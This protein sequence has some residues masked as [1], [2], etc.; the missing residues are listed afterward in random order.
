MVAGVARGA[1]EVTLCFTQPRFARP[2]AL[3]TGVVGAV[4]GT[5]ARFW[6]PPDAA[7]VVAPRLDDVQGAGDDVVTIAGSGSTSNLGNF[8]LV[9]P[10]LSVL[11]LNFRFLLAPGAIVFN[12]SSL[13]K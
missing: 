2:R 3:K 12:N 11:S 13:N 6:S 1:W 4:F 7:A 10:C 5:L 9:Q 8:H